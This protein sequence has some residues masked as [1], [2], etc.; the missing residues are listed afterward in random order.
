MKNEDNLLLKGHILF[1]LYKYNQALEIYNQLEHKFGN[2]STLLK[3]R[4]NIYFEYK[5]DDNALKCFLVYL[6]QSSQDNEV[7]LNIGLSYLHQGEKENSEL[8][9]LKVFQSDPTN[10][11]A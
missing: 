7:N 6:D 3:N 4:G 9:F 11:K 10:S 2:D 1:N 8:Y 5:D